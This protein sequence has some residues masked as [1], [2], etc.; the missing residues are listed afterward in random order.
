M[1]KGWQVNDLALCIK[2]GRWRDSQTGEVVEIGPQAGQF[3]T[4]TRVTRGWVPANKGKVLLG[5]KGHGN[6]LFA[7]SRFVK[8][9]PD[10]MLENDA[11]EIISS[12]RRQAE[13]ALEA[14]F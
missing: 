14:Q 10:K 12:E 13:H 3:L 8:I 7:A 5:F 1:A 6:D 11:E 9:K 4:V 2:Q